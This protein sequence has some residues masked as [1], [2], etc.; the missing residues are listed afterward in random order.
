MAVSFKLRAGVPTDISECFDSPDED[1]YFL[2][3]MILT[4]AEMRVLLFSTRGVDIPSHGTSSLERSRWMD[5]CWTG[6]LTEKVTEANLESERWKDD[7][8]Q[9]TLL[10]LKYGVRL[11]S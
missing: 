1:A 8:H 2:F 6:P 5:G 11:T 7:R 10:C 4:K 9:Q 3:L